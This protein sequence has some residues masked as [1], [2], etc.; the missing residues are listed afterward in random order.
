MARLVPS[1]VTVRNCMSG[2]ERAIPGV[3][4]E[5]LA[6][7]ISRRWCGSIRRHRKTAPHQLHWQGLP[8]GRQ[9]PHLS[10]QL[11]DQ[12]TIF[13]DEDKIKDAKPDHILDYLRTRLSTVFA[14][15]SNAAVLCNS[16]GFP[17]FALVMGVSNPRA[18]TQ[19][20]KICNHLIDQLSSSKS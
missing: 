7:G 6:V 17:L 11:P 19:A 14:A 8:D 12:L 15:V 4:A 13:G 1:V 5:P 16:R 10:W 3:G 9:G 2:P 18:K 20:L